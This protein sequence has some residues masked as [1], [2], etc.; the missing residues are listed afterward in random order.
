MSFPLCLLPFQV[1]SDTVLVRVS[2]QPRDA[3]LYMKGGAPPAAYRL[4]W[5]LGAAIA[6]SIMAYFRLSSEP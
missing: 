4:G 2:P 3:P 5:A 6:V 1:E